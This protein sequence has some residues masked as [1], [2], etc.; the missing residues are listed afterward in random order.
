MAK[1]RHGKKKNQKNRCCTPSGERENFNN[2]N[3]KETDF[4]ARKS[5]SINLNENKFEN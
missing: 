1:I 2:N 4:T 5:H 3:N